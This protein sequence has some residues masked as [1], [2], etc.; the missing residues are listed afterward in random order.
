[1]MNLSRHLGNILATRLGVKDVTENT[2]WSLCQVASRAIAGKEGNG[3][4]RLVP[5]TDTMKHDEAASKYVE[6]T[7]K[8]KMEDG[9]FLDA[10]EDHEGIFVARGQKHGERKPLKKGQELMANHNV[11]AYS[12]LDWFLNMGYIPP[13]RTGKWTMLEAGLPH[14]YRG[15]FSRKSNTGPV[16]DSGA[17]GSGKPEIQVIRQH[18]QQ[19]QQQQ[20][21]CPR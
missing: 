16:K 9:N 1:M 21:S 13:E 4:L 17:F 19:Q 6:L 10:N 14:S 11:P 2:S 20:Q 7:C 8:E 15:G 3:S 5:V 12:P 18:T